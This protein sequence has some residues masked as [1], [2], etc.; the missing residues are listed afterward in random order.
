[1]ERDENEKDEKSMPKRDLFLSIFSQQ[2]EFNFEI[3]QRNTNYL[4]FTSIIG[5]FH[6]SV[7]S[8]GFISRALNK[9]TD[10]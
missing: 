4:Y 8:P 5:P 10:D 2:S 1:M 3:P 6:E 9:E 7:P